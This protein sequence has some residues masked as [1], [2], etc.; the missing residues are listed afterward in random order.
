MAYKAPSLLEQLQK[1]LAGTGEPLSVKED[2]KQPGRFYI[3]KAGSPTKIPIVLNK[4]SQNN[5]PGKQ[6]YLLSSQTT[7]SLSVI[8]PST[9]ASVNTQDKSL[10][11]QFNYREALSNLAMAAS[12]GFRTSEEERANGNTNASPVDAFYKVIAR[13]SERLGLAP[14]PVIRAGAELESSSIVQGMAFVAQ[15]LP[16]APQQVI[17]QPANYDYQIPSL[18]PH[19]VTAAR[20]QF[21][22]KKNTD[23][24]TIGITDQPWQSVANMEFNVKGNLQPGAYDRV[25]GVYE[26]GQRT[27]TAVEMNSDK[28]AKRVHIRYGNAPASPWN[29]DA[30]GIL[31]PVEPA[32]IRG[33]GQRANW[34]T[35]NV[36]GPTGERRPVEVRTML[37]DSA[38]AVFPGGAITYNNPKDINPDVYGPAS[39]R[40]QQ[41]EINDVLSFGTEGNR[42]QMKEIAGTNVKGGRSRAVIGYQEVPGQEEKQKVSLPGKPS[43]FMVRSSVLSIPAYYNKTTGKFVATPG[44]DTESTEGLV[45]I[46]K[47]RMGIDVERNTGATAQAFLNVSGV[48]LTDSGSVKM[49]GIKVGDML[50]GQKQSVRVGGKN[51]PISMALADVKTD[52][53]VGGFFNQMSYEQTSSLFRESAAV[54]GN[55]GDARFAEWFAKRYAPKVSLRYNEGRSQKL[56]KAEEIQSWNMERLAQRYSLTTGQETSAQTLMNTAFTN[57]IANTDQDDV[58]VQARNLKKYGAGWVEKEQTV[59]KIMSNDTMDSLRRAEEYAWAKKNK[60]LEGF[61]QYFSQK[62]TKGE[63][64]EGTENSR[65]NIKLNKGLVMPVGVSQATEWGGWDP[66]I[67]STLR[68]TV[69]RLYPEFAKETGID[70]ESG[71]LSRAGEYASTLQAAI[72][73]QTSKMAGELEGELP[74]DIHQ[75]SIENARK[76][77]SITQDAAMS[78]REKLA[79]MDRVLGSPKGLL[80]FPGSGT[81]VPGPATMQGAVYKSGTREFSGL[82]KPYLEGVARLSRAEDIEGGVS[83]SLGHE[84]MSRFFNKATQLLTSGGESVKSQS[85]L[86]MRGRGV[87]GAIAGSYSTM[88]AL[89]ANQIFVSEKMTDALVRRFGFTNEKDVARISKQLQE[90]SGVQAIAMRYPQTAE[91]Q[92]VYGMNV[93]FG[94]GLER[95]IGK[96]AYASIS[97]D[98]RGAV[99]YG[100]ST[101]FGEAG[102]GDSDKDKFMA[103]LG[104]VRKGN[105]LVQTS[106]TNMPEQL[107]NERAQQISNT[108]WPGEL[109]N[110]VSAMKQGAID[111]QSKG[112]PVVEAIKKRT[113]YPLRDAAENYLKF[114]QSK[115][116][117]GIDYNLGNALIAQ[118][119]A[120]GGK[121]LESVANVRPAGY[122]I[123]L[124]D[125]TKNRQGGTDLAKVVSGMNFKMKGENAVLEG[126]GYQNDETGGITRASSNSPG[127]MRTLA[128]DL[129]TV[130][131]TPL[132]GKSGEIHPYGSRA[133]ASL[134]GTSKD[135]QD[136]LFSNL[137]KTTTSEQRKDVIQDYVAG[138]SQ[139]QAHNVPVVRASVV[140]ATEKAINQNAEG[141]QESMGKFMGSAPM[142]WRNRILAGATKFTS[143]GKRRG[144]ILTMAAHAIMNAVRQA[145]NDEAMQMIARNM[146]LQDVAQASMPQP[147]EAIVEAQTKMVQSLTDEAYYM[148][149]GSLTKEQRNRIDAGEAKLEDFAQPGAL[150]SGGN[151]GQPP[152]E[153][154]S[155]GLVDPESGEPRKKRVGKDS[156][157]LVNSAVERANQASRQVQ[158]QHGFLSPAKSVGRVKKE[159]TEAYARLGSAMPEAARLNARLESALMKL[160]PNLNLTQTPMHEAISQ[161]MERDSEGFVQ[162]LGPDLKRMI[163]VG[164]EQDKASMAWAGLARLREQGTPLPKEL[165]PSS[166]EVRAV[167]KALQESGDTASGKSP[168]YNMGQVSRIFS[169]S[170]AKVGISLPTQEL[171]NFNKLLSEQKQAYKDLKV[172]KETDKKQIEDEIGL[173]QKRID[174][175][176]PGAIVA[177][178]ISA[179]SQLLGRYED[180]VFDA[181]RTG[182]RI[183]PAILNKIDTE[184]NRLEKLQ[185]RQLR[186]GQP[187]EDDERGP[188]GFFRKTFGGF[189]MMYIG[190]ITN[191][192]T[193]GLGKGMDD[194]LKLEQGITQAGNLQYGTRGVAY[195]QAQILANQIALNG[196]NNNPLM[197][198]Q[199]LVTQNTPMQAGLNMASAGIGAFAATSWL[200]GNIGGPS[201]A[202]LQKAAGPIGLALAGASYAADVYQRAQDPQGLGYRLGRGS[203]PEQGW[204]GFSG[205]LNVAKFLD[206]DRVALSFMRVGDQASQRDYKNAVIAQNVYSKTSAGLLSGKSMR[207]IMADQSIEQEL[208]GG[209]KYFMGAKEQDYLPAVIKSLI[210]E[211][212]S[213]SQQSATRTA[214]LMTRNKNRAFSTDIQSRLLA[215]YESAMPSEDLAV[216][217]LAAVGGNAG[218][219][220]RDKDRLLLG[221]AGGKVPFLDAKNIKGLMDINLTDE[222][223]AVLS[224]GIQAASALNPLATSRIPGVGSMGG[225]EVTPEKMMAFYN[226]LSDLVNTPAMDVV[227]SQMNTYSIG[228]MIGRGDRS[229]LDISNLTPEMTPLE[230]TR[231]TSRLDAQSGV[232][233]QRLGF[234]Q[235]M[236]QQMYNFGQQDLGNK[237]YDQVVKPGIA[238]SQMWLAQRVYQGDPM[239]I[240]RMGQLGFDFNSAPGMKTLNGTTIGAQYAAFTDVSLGNKITGMNWG[241]SSFQVGTNQSQL[242]PEQIER[243]KY[244]PFDQQIKPIQSAI[245]ARQIGNNIWGSGMAGNYNAGLIGAGVDGFNLATPMTLPDG[246]TISS[247]GGKQGMQLYMANQNR[248]FQLQQQTLSQRGL[249]LQS[250]YMYG[251]W[252]LQDENRA[253]SNTQ[254]QWQFGFQQRQLD[255]SNRHWNEDYDLNLREKTI[256]RSWAIQDLSIDNR[257]RMMQRDWT[258]Q[259]WGYQDQTRD[260]NWGW[261][262]QDFT[263]EKRFL[264]GRQRK[265][266]ERQQDRATT[267]HGLEGEQITRQRSRQETLWAL[268]DE[269]VARNIDRQRQLWA[270]EDERF[271]LQ[272]RQHNE[273]AKMQQESLDK[274]KEFYELNRTLE[275]KRIVFERQYQ[276]EQLALQQANLDLQVQQSQTQYEFSQT[277]MQ[278][279]IYM[280]TVNGQLKTLT[281]DSLTGVL[282]KITSIVDQLLRLNDMN[283]PTGSSNNSIKDVIPTYIESSP[284]GSG[285]ELQ[286]IIVNVGN[287]FLK[288]FVVNTVTHEVTNGN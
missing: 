11:T 67:N 243:N 153:P 240:A 10:P 235:K 261:Q 73:W 76:I 287:E 46:Y 195:N 234:A 168:M 144:G 285:G 2:K 71:K 5:D 131:T 219:I 202:M 115:G 278:L 81:I 121:N 151:N 40:S 69:N 90:M 172:A 147:Q 19:Q 22:A 51:V 208:G 167:G 273:Q 4:S 239:A 111:A 9:Q 15:A 47:E 7:N 68:G 130:A 32:Q 106:T 191:L 197:A 61:D 218:S 214:L 281:D 154:P 114:S 160:D 140:R 70:Y 181:A 255:M 85:G 23:Q 223:R 42:L 254:Q 283:I 83:A 246:S 284:N 127:D 250:S 203:G 213:F 210:T 74:K 21:L 179:S 264:T 288:R 161:A 137:E 165:E 97:G 58:A 248:Q 95:M 146:G 119:T 64:V 286:P 134:F 222:Q 16:V 176:K 217:M 30:N 78:P 225:T 94:K 35:S 65:W 60:N 196:T 18:L 126:W 199:G 205:P 183:D 194:R 54:S 244:L 227:K 45:S 128:M 105:E 189:G 93:V 169:P 237:I 178:Q 91:G 12:E 209:Q 272:K 215:D 8:Q 201:G 150:S 125:L 279:D 252:G 113:L 184:R 112:N 84:M 280:E 267:M 79:E 100:V 188:S 212:P 37:L 192:A 206:P 274:S 207:D 163:R 1:A 238:D 103:L 122:Q 101:A 135:D 251:N 116:A 258:R 190:S 24:G 139:E 231:Q 49:A 282:G 175:E 200:A 89:P 108:L 72:G 152:V 158:Q 157:N 59:Q 229:L 57:V 87:G 96:E 171:E 156:G 230:A 123:S 13:G 53:I 233:Q 80:Q 132:Q 75:V 120:F 55:E 28:S 52:D 145:P 271:A 277:M 185:E 29:Y 129:A 33:I 216:Q 66:R 50:A 20:K 164:K 253:L 36:V 260:L 138:L 180:Q 17:G 159:I 232:Y 166:K 149:Y 241:T 86:P 269:R 148:A 186:M 266:A 155:P 198:L 211:N 242:T 41:I 31:Q 48:H 107:T 14:S 39:T 143:L 26:G 34:A 177:S 263:E 56:R 259:D 182:K 221:S 82:A 220:Y 104:L 187:T 245:S 136:A 226:K 6:S 193:Q 62:Y 262:Q 249:D 265:I 173:R 162:E 133:L 98:A 204:L 88:P 77:A 276:T 38:L 275:E 25:I 236:Q 92:S 44:Q 256:K 124:D 110:Q 99:K 117:V 27:G 170:D 257:S 43:D 63:Q 118:E 174:Q 109:G 142:G 268:E 3:E 224:G 102:A 247:V 270:L 228:S 141:S